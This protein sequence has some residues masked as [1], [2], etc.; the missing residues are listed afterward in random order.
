LV[1][2][3][4]AFGGV[5]IVTASY[6]GTLPDNAADFCKWLTN[7]RLAA[8]A[9]RGVNYSVFGCG[10][11][12]WAATFQA[13]PRLLD[14][15]LAAHGAHRLSPRGDFD[16]QF[17]S[18]SRPFW[19]T[20]AGHFGIEADAAA[21]AREPLYRVEILSDEPLDALARSTGSRAMRVVVNRELHRK[22]GAHPSE[23]LDP[24]S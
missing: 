16:S 17:Q 19:S 4:P 9:L 13:N 5:I 1:G 8:D 15:Q 23:R 20:I 6:N 22:E 11:R 10:K 21:G 14:E 12:D 7:G 18:W 3:L 2:E 24:P